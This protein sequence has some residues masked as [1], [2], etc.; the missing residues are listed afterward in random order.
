MEDVTLIVRSTRP[1]SDCISRIG[2]KTNTSTEETENL[3]DKI[4]KLIAGFPETSNSPSVTLDL[5][6]PTLLNIS[7]ISHHKGV[8]KRYFT[9]FIKEGNVWC[10]VHTWLDPRFHDIDGE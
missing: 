2:K 1:L 8:E 4:V 10:Q 9:R 6:S 3:S 7:L 5:Q